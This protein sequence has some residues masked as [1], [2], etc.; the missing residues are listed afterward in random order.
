MLLKIFLIVCLMASSRRLQWL[1]TE[2]HQGR[3]A[4]VSFSY[5]AVTKREK[6]KFI[7]DDAYNMHGVYRP[8]LQGALL[9]A[10]HAFHSS[11]TTDK[12]HTS[13][14]G[15]TIVEFWCQ[16]LPEPAL[17]VPLA[18]PMADK[19]HI[20]SSHDTDRNETKRKRVDAEIDTSKLASAPTKEPLTTEIL[21]MVGAWATLQVS[22]LEESLKAKDK[23]GFIKQMWQ[24]L[25]AATCVVSELFHSAFDGYL[26]TS[27]NHMVTS[28]GESEKEAAHQLLTNHFESLWPACIQRLLSRSCFAEDGAEVTSSLPVA[29]SGSGSST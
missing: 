15:C 29:S 6:V 23:K 16:Q 3:S 26:V 10:Q 12:G 25:P 17:E 5:N 22:M 4:H 13:S 27:E 14:K 18:V 19:T 2:L 24:D 1:I 9:S 11:I 20:E 21:E 8:C 7:L 28:L